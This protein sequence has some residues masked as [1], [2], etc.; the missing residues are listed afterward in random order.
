[1]KHNDELPWPLTENGEPEEPVFIGNIGGSALDFEL[2]LSMMRSYGVPTL[3]SYPQSG[4]FMKVVFGYTGGGMD[5]YV[6]KSMEQLGRTLLTAEGEI[7]DEGE[8]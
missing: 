8:D 7:R 5:I 1:M 4:R 3:L 2:I 6:P